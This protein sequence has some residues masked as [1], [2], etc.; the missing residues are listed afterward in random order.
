MSE[1]KNPL[2]KWILI[3]S[4]LFALLE[5]FV[6]LALIF[7]P[8]SVLETVDLQAKG[9]EYLVYMWAARQFALGF[10]LGFSTFK[11]VHP[12]ADN[13]IYFPFS[14]V[15]WGLFNWNFTERKFSCH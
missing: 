2:P 8:E 12:H 11:K 5:I 6:S 13:C 10:I 15:C 1:G 3:I 14:H 4:G 9:V 7:S